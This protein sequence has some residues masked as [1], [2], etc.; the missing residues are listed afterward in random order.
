MSTP[1]SAPDDRAA[2]ND[3]WRKWVADG[4][5]VSAKAAAQAQAVR[6]DITRRASEARSGAM[7]E[8]VPG[9]TP[10]ARPAGRPGA[11]PEARPEHAPGPALR[12]AASKARSMSPDELEPHVAA[13]LEAYGTVSQARVKRD[14]HVST[15]K[16]AEA[17][18]LAKR[19]RTLVPLGQR[20]G[21]Q[22]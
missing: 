9:D 16:A 18:R 3:R 1:G 10:E 8:T 5:A 7:P 20:A 2:G 15:E 21:G 22:R 19:N 4:L 12:L 17:L 6:E 13:M 11:R 14:L